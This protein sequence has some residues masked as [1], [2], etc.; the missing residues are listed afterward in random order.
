MA[1]IVFTED[2]RDDLREL[3]RSHELPGSANERIRKTLEPL[4]TFPDSGARLA[5]RRRELRFV[6]GPW[7]WMILVY[8]YDRAGDE[9]A[10]LRIADGRMSNSPHRLDG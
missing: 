10:I 7:A 9:V 4:R 5:G 8:R 6:I 2:A 3:I 1:S